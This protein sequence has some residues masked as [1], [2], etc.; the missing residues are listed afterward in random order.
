MP[1]P[2]VPPLDIDA[3]IADYQTGLGLLALSRKYHI[4]MR[5]LRRG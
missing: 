2:K 1:G 4:H 3:I 5:R